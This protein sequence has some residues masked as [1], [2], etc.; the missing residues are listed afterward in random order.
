[1][2]IVLLEKLKVPLPVHKFPVLYATCKLCTVYT[3]DGTCPC[4]EPHKSKLR[5]SYF[6]K[7]HFNI[8]PSSLRVSTWAFFFIFYFLNFRCVI[9]LVLVK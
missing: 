7:T 3:A 5:P 6:M 9:P 1:M 2:S 8:L 4:P